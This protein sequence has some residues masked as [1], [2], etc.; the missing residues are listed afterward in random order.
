MTNPPA[1]NHSQK[2]LNY[3]TMLIGIDLSFLE[4]YYVCYHKIRLE[5]SQKLRKISSEHYSNE[6]KQTNP[7]SIH[8][9][10]QV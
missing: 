8:K 3:F 10:I 2:L 9:Q 7:P 4:Y 5:L 6:D 1:S